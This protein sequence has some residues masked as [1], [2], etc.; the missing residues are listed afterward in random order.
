MWKAD[1][2]AASGAEQLRPGVSGRAASPSG[3]SIVITGELKASEDLTIEGQV[4]GKIELLENVLTIGR[5]AKARAEILAKTVIIL[6]E[7]VGNI[8]ASEK[9]ELMDSGSVEGDIVSPRLAVADGA[10]FRG[11]V[12]MSQPKGRTGPSATL[13]PRKLESPAQSRPG[14]PASSTSQTS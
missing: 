1:N 12:D 7:V 4:D 14:V 13:A 10:S 6:G 2:A 9:V 8:T 3:G 11:R 5:S